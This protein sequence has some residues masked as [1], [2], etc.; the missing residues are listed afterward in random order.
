MLELFEW[1]LAELGGF[2]Y[3]FKIEVKI[4]EECIV[5]EVVVIIKSSF[6]PILLNPRSK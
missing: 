4:V 5:V 2:I 6:K 3:D 1:E